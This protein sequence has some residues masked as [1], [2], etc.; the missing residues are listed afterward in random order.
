MSRRRLFIVGWFLGG[1]MSSALSM[2]YQDSLGLEGYIN[3]LRNHW[4]NTPLWL[5]LAVWTVA[6]GICIT[7]YGA[8]KP[9]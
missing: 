5:G 1:L 6:L 2:A 9:R 3:H 4:W 7:I 8:E